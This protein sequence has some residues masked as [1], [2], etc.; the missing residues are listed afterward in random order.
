MALLVL[1]PLCCALKA[2]SMT[3][4]QQPWIRATLWDI[5]SDACIPRASAMV[6]GIRFISF[7]V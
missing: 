6:R 1:W 7:Y 3:D 2:L 5:G 4:S